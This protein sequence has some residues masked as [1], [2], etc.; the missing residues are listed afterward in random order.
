MVDGRKKG[1]SYERKITRQ[2]TA[3]TN[4]AYE[5]YRSPSSG[6]YASQR[7]GLENLD[8]DI[9]PPTAIADRFPF[10]LE[11]KNRETWKGTLNSVFHNNNDIPS[12][13]EQGFGDAIRANK[14]PLVLL[15]ANHTK[16]YMIIPH[17]ELLEHY[18]STRGLP[19]M[20]TDVSYTNEMLEET[21]SFKVLVLVWDD[22]LDE[23]KIED[24][25]KSSKAWFSDWYEK[26]PELSGLSRETGK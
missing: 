20:S 17:S 25:L 7:V 26:L 10:S 18:F 5:F 1:S 9:I 23:F 12:Y 8:G 16:N 11:L 4:G 15:H 3:W 14:V 19:W 13:I 2:L 6:S 22:F 24:V 21:Y